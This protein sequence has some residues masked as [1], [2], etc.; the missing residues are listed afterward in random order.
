MDM[1][2][3]LTQAGISTAFISLLLG[4][5]KAVNG[6]RCRSHCCGR[7]LD[8]DFKVDNMPPSPEIVINN[9]SLKNNIEK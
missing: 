4:I 7:Q 3:S 1:N 8:L 2:N 6:K 5:Y 9:P